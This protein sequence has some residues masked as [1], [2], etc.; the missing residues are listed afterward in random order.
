MRKKLK[1]YD[2]LLTDRTEDA[3][4]DGQAL[5]ILIGGLIACV[6]MLIKSL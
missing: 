1:S 2:K 6:V 5:G 4:K 3:L